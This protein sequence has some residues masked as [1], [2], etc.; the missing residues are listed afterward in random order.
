MN[1]PVKILTG[2]WIIFF[3]YW[4]IN[5][6]NAKKTA[7]R[8]NWALLLAYKI[9]STLGGVLFFWPDRPNPLGMILFPHT[10]WVQSLGAGLCVFG[11]LGAI[12]SRA[13]LAGNWSPDVTFKVGHELTQ[14]GPYRFVRHP[15]YTGI[16]LMLLGTAVCAGRLRALIGFS[17]VAASFWIKL[18]QEETLMIRHFP[19]DYPAYKARVKALVPFLF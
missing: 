1:I 17:L 19:N 10:V 8:Q 4:I 5:L 13:I 16:L 6:L 12:W 14:R 3:L 2:C 15:I 9:P 11:L 7:E 18:R